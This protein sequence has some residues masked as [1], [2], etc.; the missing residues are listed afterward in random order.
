MLGV[1]RVRFR[2]TNGREDVDVLTFRYTFIAN[3]WSQHALDKAQKLVYI[4]FA[5]SHPNS[6]IVKAELLNDIRQEWAEFNQR[7]FVS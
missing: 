2:N 6:A 4:N 5:A 3:P 1:V 7:G